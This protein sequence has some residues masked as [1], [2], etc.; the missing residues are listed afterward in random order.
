[1]NDF[2]RYCA[3]LDGNALL[4]AA[5]KTLLWTAQ[6]DSAG[7]STEYGIGFE[8]GSFRGE[9]RIGHDGAQ[10]KVRT[11][12]SLFPDRRLCVVL[13]TNAEYAEAGAIGEALSRVALGAVT[14]VR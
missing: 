12:L 3:A 10:E 2:A 6:K 11:V 8:V 4:T 9:R 14:L 5:D 1:V 7:K 13:M